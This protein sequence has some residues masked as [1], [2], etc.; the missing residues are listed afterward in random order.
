VAQRSSDWIDVYLARPSGT[1]VTNDAFY[2]DAF[3]LTASGL[4]SGHTVSSNP[5]APG[6]NPAGGWQVQYGDAFGAAF[7]TGAG[8]DNTLYPNSGGA[9]SRLQCSDNPGFANDEMEVFNCS[10][11]VVDSAGLHLKCD[12]SPERWPAGA[13]P[14]GAPGNPAINYVC[15]ALRSQEGAVPGYKFFNWQPRQGQTW[16]MQCVCRFPPDTGA[17]DPGSWSTDDPWTQEIDFFEGW[18]EHGTS[19]ADAPVTT[20]TWVYDTNPFTTQGGAG[21]LAFDPSAAYHTYT[22]VISPDNTYEEFIDGQLQT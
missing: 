3:T 13:G 14:N 8:Q 10:Q 21:V 6:V 4:P 2:A 12:S 20:P 11:A 9:Y 19:W 17:A 16:A 7:G 1:V 5:D 18:G 22:T 15:G